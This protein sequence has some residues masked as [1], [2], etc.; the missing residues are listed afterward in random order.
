[1]VAQKTIGEMTVVERKALLSTVAEA[2]LTCAERAA[3]DGD[4]RSE[5]NSL[6][7]ASIIMGS[8]DELA[9]VRL[10]AAEIVLQQAISLIESSRGR[11]DRRVL[12]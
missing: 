7:T 9:R 8:L 5:A 10:D 3:D 6:S 11:S 4:F 2:L 1:M 12:H